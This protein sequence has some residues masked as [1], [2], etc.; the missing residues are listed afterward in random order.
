[1][2]WPWQWRKKWAKARSRCRKLEGDITQL[3]RRN[4]ALEQGKAHLEQENGA[5]KLRLHDLEC[6]VTWLRELQEAGVM[7]IVVSK[8]NMDQFVTAL[9]KLQDN[10]KGGK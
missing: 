6:E 2:T 7:A 3:E 1:M 8:Q 5:I 9:K 4:K 10:S